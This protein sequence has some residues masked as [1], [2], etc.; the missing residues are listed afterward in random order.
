MGKGDH[1]GEMAILTH[2]RS[3]MNAFSLSFSIHEIFSRKDYEQLKLEY[4][5]IEKRLK[6]GLRIY[7]REDKTAVVEQM[8]RCVIFEQL[9][10][11]E[12]GDLYLNYM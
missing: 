1:F 11:F 4:P 2:W 7:K 8:R 3:D 5:D 10:E 6:I 12:L 9:S